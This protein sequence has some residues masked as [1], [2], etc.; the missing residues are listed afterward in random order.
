MSLLSLPPILLDH[1]TPLQPHTVF[2]LSSLVK[3]QVFHILP[4][5]DLYPF[6]PRVLPREIFVQDGFEISVEAAQEPTAVDVE[7]PAKKKKGRPT[8]RDKKKKAILALQQVDKWL[9]KNS[10]TIQ[11]PEGSLGPPLTSH[12]LISNPP[13]TTLDKYRTQKAALLE[14]ITTGDDVQHAMAH[15]AL[16]KANH[17]VLAR[18]RRL[19]EIAAEKGLEVGGEGGDRTGLERVERAVAELNAGDRAYRGGILGL[20][21]G[22]GLADLDE[23][24]L[25]SS[26]SL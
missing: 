9:E 5:S 21:E 17:S 14:A 26:T 6:N 22:G 23:T 24:Q 18:M 19:D 10:V 16:E 1:L 13:T 15:R 11:P 2:V 25:A 12:V 8:K 3:A 7:A 4:S 20:L